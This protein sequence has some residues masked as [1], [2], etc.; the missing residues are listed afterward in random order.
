MKATGIVRRIDDLGRVVIP[1]KIRRT[2]RI[3]EGDPLQTI[4]TSFDRFYAAIH[5]AHKRT[6]AEHELRCFIYGKW[7]SEHLLINCLLFDNLRKDRAALNAFFVFAE[8]Y[9]MAVIAS[10]IHFTGTLGCCEIGRDFLRSARGNL[11]G[12]AYFIG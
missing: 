2:M 11:F 8:L 6:T 5:S 4:L 9:A 1:K 12:R 7:V 10:N 3:R